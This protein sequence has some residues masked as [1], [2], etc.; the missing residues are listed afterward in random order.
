MAVI[1]HKRL[2]AAVNEWETNVKSVRRARWLRF[3]ATA[4]WVYTHMG[5]AYHS[6]AAKVAIISRRRRILAKARARWVLRALSAAFQGLQAMLGRCI[7]SR[8][9]VERA[10][11]KIL[12]RRLNA[13]VNHWRLLLW[14]ARS[15]ELQRFVHSPAPRCGN[16]DQLDARIKIL[17][18]MLQTKASKLETE[19][20]L[21]D[22]YAQVQAPRI[23]TGCCTPLTVA[24]DCCRRLALRAS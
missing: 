21:H 8:L 17:E 23:G 2:N 11:Q 20:A 5:R 12:H 1:L 13:A 4:Q 22:N 14:Q 3:K 16:C 18:A 19:K 7:R 6:W 15:A 9:L 10:S 24:S